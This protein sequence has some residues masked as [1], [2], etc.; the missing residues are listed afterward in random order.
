[1]AELFRRY[2][3]S[4]RVKEYSPTKNGKYDNMGENVE[5][6]ELPDELKSPLESISLA[7]KEEGTTGPASP[8]MSTKSKQTK[9]STT[10][11]ISR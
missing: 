7:P 9:K 5:H 11:K 10:L 6:Q 1:M 8:T 4:K 2:R 3:F